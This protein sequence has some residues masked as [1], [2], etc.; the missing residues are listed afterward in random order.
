MGTGLPSALHSNTASWASP[1]LTSFFIVITGDVNTWWV[2]VN[3]TEELRPETRN[4]ICLLFIQYKNLLLYR[5][6]Q[7]YLQVYVGIVTEPVLIC[8]TSIGASILGTQAT[9][10]Q[11]VVCYCDPE[12][13]FV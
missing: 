3:H 7:T 6:Q 1:I 10:D 11:Q 4:S 5:G 12:V 2:D 13:R 8:L 9:Y